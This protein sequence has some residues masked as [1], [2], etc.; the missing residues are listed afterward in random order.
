M[1]YL[2]PEPVT[3]APGQLITVFLQGSVQG[4]I[5][6]T[7]QQTSDY[8][9]P[10]LEVVRPAPGCIV[11]PSIPCASMTAIT[12]QIPYEM[13]LPCLACALPYPGSGPPQLFVTANGAAGALFELSPLT[14]R[15]HILTTCDTVIPGGSGY[16]PCAPVVT[17]ADGSLVSSGSPAHGGEEIVAYAVGLGPT[18]PAI[19]T[20][21]AAPT[22]TPTSE[23]F[24]LDFNFR[25]NALATEPAPPFPII[26]SGAG[27]LLSFPSNQVAAGGLP[28]GPLFSGLVAGY[29]GLCQINF[30]V[31]QPPPAMQAC[32]FGTIQSNLTVSVGGLNSFDG[33][34]ICIAP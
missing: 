4:N 27:P 15:V 6:V 7:L 28:S 13:Q 8:Q 26:I 22:A 11:A 23:T 16:A 19:P 21:Q 32:S 33:A 20:G 1:G 2:Y 9:A 3:V 30:V 34:G 31:P 5:G 14:D 24:L 29:I 17:H 12:I 10:V 18:T 25:P